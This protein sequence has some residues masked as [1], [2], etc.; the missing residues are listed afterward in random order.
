[1]KEFFEV[2]DL[3]NLAR[4][5][6]SPLEAIMFFP[7][8]A[9]AIQKYT[10]HVIRLGLDFDANHEKI[11]NET[12]EERRVRGNRI[13]GGL[14]S[15]NCQDEQGVRVMSRESFDAMLDIMR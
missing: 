9:D 4:A 2:E 1:M 13:S 12:S 6:I 8:V 10:E 3:D 7:K 15:K 14:Y 11:K 5:K